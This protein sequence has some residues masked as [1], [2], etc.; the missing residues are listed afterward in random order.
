MVAAV[1]VARESHSQPA[2]A[3]RG[4]DHVANPLVF[5]TWA[6]V[7]PVLWECSDG[8]YVLPC[9]QNKSFGHNDTVSIEPC[10]LRGLAAE[11]PQLTSQ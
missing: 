11:L 5:V 6:G 8:F 4:T 10:A 7:H 3:H 1:T 9:W 2:H